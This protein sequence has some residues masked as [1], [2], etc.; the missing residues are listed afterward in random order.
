M[1]R[2]YFTKIENWKYCS[3][4]IFKYINNN[5]K[6]LKNG[7][8][9]SIYS[10]WMQS[11]PWKTNA[12]L[13]KKIKKG[14]RGRSKTW[15]VSEHVRPIKEV[16]V[17]FYF[18]WIGMKALSQTKK[19]KKK[20]IGMK[21]RGGAWEV[22]ENARPRSYQPFL[23]HLNVG[24]KTCGGTWQ[25]SEHTRAIHSFSAGAELRWS[26]GGPWPPLTFLILH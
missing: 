5:K 16:S 13:K 10:I 20:K 14:K 26:L 15:Q 18:I 19:E 1:D 24:K 11:L 21:T 7:I 3:K 2:T 23:F 22:L 17:F 9:E 12:Y 4:I 25:V 8:Y 6:I